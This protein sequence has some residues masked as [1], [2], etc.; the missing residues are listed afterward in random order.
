MK[1]EQELISLIKE[2]SELNSLDDIYVKKILSL[3]FKDSANSVFD[4][5]TSFQQCKRSK[6]CKELVTN[7]RKHL[8]TVYGLFILEPLISFQKII[9]SLKSFESE[10]INK[11]LLTHQ[12]TNERFSSYDE[13]YSVIFEKLFKKGLPKNFSLGDF[14]CGCNPFAYNYLPIKPNNY[15]AI[16][17]SSEDMS[18]TQSF[19]NNTN[20][21]GIA[22]AFDLMSDEFF[23]W[24]SQ[25]SFDL[26][27]LFKALDSFETIKRHSSKKILSKI[28]ASFFVVTFPLISI[29][30]KQSIASSKR[31]WFEN[32]CTKNDWKFEIFIIGNEQIF[33]VD[34]RK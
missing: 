9:S 13:F 25:Q 23:S 5:Y 34:A 6:K 29:G 2:K 33:L 1:Y 24:I 11:I 30:G 16:D 28:N 15:L 10:S 3:Y 26:V 12:S 7:V 27:F 18:L 17:L 20:I 14:A 21:S 32:F 19:F 8:R 22:K 31:W 4:K